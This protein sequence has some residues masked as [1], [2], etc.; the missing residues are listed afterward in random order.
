MADNLN[1]MLGNALGM[2]GNPWE[3][4]GMLEN[5]KKTFYDVRV[6]SETLVNPLESQ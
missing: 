3:P 4:F 6:A 2:L 5:L 1:R